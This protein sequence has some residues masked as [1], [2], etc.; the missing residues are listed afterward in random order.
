MFQYARIPS[1]LAKFDALSKFF[2]IICVAIL[3]FIYPP[4]YNLILFIVILLTAIFLGHINYGRLKGA[5]SILL[6]LAL[7][8][9]LGGF[10]YK[11]E[12]P[13]FSLGS[14]IYYKE[15]LIVRG[16][17]AARI[18]NIMLSS[19]LFVWVTNPRDFVNGLVKLGMPYRIAFTIFVGLNYIPILT[20]EMGYISDAQKLRGLRRDKSIK[21]RLV[22]YK[23]FLVAVLLRSLRKTQI[24]AFALDSKAFGASTERTYLNQFHWSTGGI[25]WLIFWII[26]VIASLVAEL[27]LHLFTGHLLAY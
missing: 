10:S 1:I 16:A 2:W 9:L 24:T 27:G 22:Q 5:L 12:T 14:F 20:N 11:G 4:E 21:G 6:A 8:F 18:L 3:V 13:L 26:L 23:T 17:S 25:G 15:G 19:M 7:L